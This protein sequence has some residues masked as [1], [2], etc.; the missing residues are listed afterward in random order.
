VTTNTLTA[1]P[2]VA[3]GIWALDTR[4]STAS[5]KARRLFGLMKVSGEI[6][7][8]TGTVIVTDT[9]AMMSVAAVLD[10][11]GINTGKA[12]RDKHLREVVL[13]VVNHP[14]LT[15]RAQGVVPTKGGWRTDGDLTVRG[16]TAHVKLDIR[17][18]ELVNSIELRATGSL[19][20]GEFGVKTKRRLVRDKVD[21]KIVA[22]LRWDSKIRL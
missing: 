20:V 17:L 9:I 7:I 1:T 18:V 22:R 5:F 8:A 16:R 21:I 13:D 2:P 6:P 3:P 14:R 15:F 19:R 4:L 11:T 10:P 12:K